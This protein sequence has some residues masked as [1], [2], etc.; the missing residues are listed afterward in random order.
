MQ[1]PKH[2][3]KKILSAIILHNKIAL[4]KDLAPQYKD[5]CQII[6]DA[7]K[8]DIFRVMAENFTHNLPEKEGVTLNV[9]DEPLRYSKHILEKAMQK[10]DINY[11]DL[12]YINDFKIL[13]C[14]WI[15]N[16]YYEESIKILKHQGNIFTILAT[17]P[18]TKEL[19]EF[20]T[21]ISTTLNAEQDKK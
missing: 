9:I 15:F 8:I 12:V 16:L 20:N 6:R 14:A 1:E 17:L 7:D 5:L 11:L 18:K 19:E 13:L 10:Q 21:L 4:P 3:Q 2:I